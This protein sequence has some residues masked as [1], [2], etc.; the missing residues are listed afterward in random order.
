M[1]ELE[2]LKQEL[3]KVNAEYAG[4]RD[5]AA[6]QR[7]EFGRRINEKKMAILAKIAE[8]EKAA[9]D[10]EVQAID[11]TAFTAPARPLRRAC[12]SASWLSAAWSC[13]VQP[14]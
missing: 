6:E 9:L 5:V 7:A 1:V 11:I 4:I 10:A 13:R 3:K 12:S 2:R 8:A 14:C